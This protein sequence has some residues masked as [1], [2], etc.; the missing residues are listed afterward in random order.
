MAII[1]YKPILEIPSRLEMFEGCLRVV[2]LEQAL[3]EHFGEKSVDRLRSYD[4]QLAAPIN[5]SFTLQLQCFPGDHLI[6]S[7]GKA[8]GRMYS[9][10]GEQVSGVSA[11]SVDLEQ[12]QLEGSSY[13][14][15]KLDL[16]PDQDFRYLKLIF[17]F[18]F[19]NNQYH[20]PSIRDGMITDC[21]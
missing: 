16:D 2:S 14:A 21:F 4:L 3:R 20:K 8:Y 19:P 6:S 17:K 12:D 7:E 11:K 5:T 10:S 13:L 15:L 1:A 9:C 18:P